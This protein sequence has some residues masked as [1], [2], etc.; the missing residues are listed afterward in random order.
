M[1]DIRWVLLIVAIAILVVA[2]I[3]TPMPGGIQ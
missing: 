2:A 1:I 3:E